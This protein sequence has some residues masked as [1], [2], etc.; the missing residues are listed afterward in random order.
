MTHEMRCGTLARRVGARLNG[1][2][3]VL[4]T[5]ATHDSRRAGPGLLFCCVPGATADGH[6]FAAQA[7][8]AGASALLCSRP[9]GLGVPELLVDE[10]RLAMAAAASEIHGRPSDSLAIV[11]IT[12]TNGKTTTAVMLA[13]VLESLGTR[14]KIIGTLT[15]ERTTP[16]STDLQRELAGMRDDGVGAVVMEVSSH[17]LTLE[18][19]ARVHFRIGVFTNLGSDHL[20]FHG[21]REK[22][23]AAK[24]KLFTPGVSET[25]VLNVDDVRGRLLADAAEIPVV[26]Y[27]LNDVSDLVMTVLGS[28]FRWRDQVVR[29]SMPGEH[30]VSN[31][32]A[33]AESALLL[34]HDPCGI[35]RALGEVE[36]VAGRFEV[37][38]ATGRDPEDGDHVVDKPVVVVDFAH[39]PDALEKLLLTARDL[40]DRSGHSGRT[41]VVF[42]CGGDRDHLKR[43]EMGRV[44]TQLADRVIVTTDNPR[45]EDPGKIIE[46][47]VAGCVWTPTVEPDRREAIRT[48]VS[49]AGGDDLVL[50]AGK[51]H[52]TGQTWNDR[53][54]PFDDRVEV[55]RALNTHPGGSENS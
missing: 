49:E 50:V 13:V 48:A 21:T 10:P 4:L 34:G 33:A 51:G 14:T 28:R 30:N 44:A 27:S 25:A 7:V 31:A 38:T 32:L 40:S 2:G 20:D 39:T 9:L 41:T 29:I 3:E 53:T 42:G 36:V 17:A 5:D 46:E 1:D 37:I 26:E 43:P 18:R 52:E 54:E 19:V 15:G 6:E 8:E 47:I 22:Y 16:E 12:G 24:A 23:F 45:S 11:G 35:A 55:T